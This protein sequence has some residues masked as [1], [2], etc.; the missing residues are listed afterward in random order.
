ML[1]DKDQGGVYCDGKKG[2]KGVYAPERGLYLELGSR[3]MLLWL[4]GPKEV[5]RPGDGMAAGASEFAPGFHI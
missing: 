3:E 2:K 1:F 4:T 5:K